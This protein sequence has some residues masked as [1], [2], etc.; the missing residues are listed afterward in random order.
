M[1]HF[2][3]CLK[4]E[5]YDKAITMRSDSRRQP[6]HAARNMHENPD[7]A[8]ELVKKQLDKIL[9]GQQQAEEKYKRLESNYQELKSS[10]SKPKYDLPKNNRDELKLDSTEKEYPS[11]YAEYKNTPAQEANKQF[12]K[13]NLRCF[14]CNRYGHISKECRQSRREKTDRLVTIDSA[15]TR[16]NEGNSSEQNFNANRVGG[17]FDT[18]TED[19]EVYLLARIDGKEHRCLLDSGCELSILPYELVKDYQLMPSY[20]RMRSANDVAIPVLG[21]VEVELE[22]E[23]LTLK[24]RFLVSNNISEIMLGFDFLKQHGIR[25]DFQKRTI[26]LKGHEIALCSSRETSWVRKLVL[27]YDVRIPPR[28]E[29][30]IPGTVLVR[31]ITSSEAWM[32]NTYE[33]KSGVCTSRTLISNENLEPMVRMINVSKEPVNIRSGTTVSELSE[34]EIVDVQSKPTD[35]EYEHLNVMMEKVDPAVPDEIRN[36]LYELLKKYSWNFSKNEY[37]LGCAKG[38]Q[39]HIDTGSAKPFRQTLRR[40]PDQ[41]LPL[42]DEQVELMLQQGIIEPSKGA[43]SSNIVL[44]KKKDGSIRPCIDLRQLNQQVRESGN[45]DIYPLPNMGACLDSMGGSKWF[46]TFDLKAGYHQIEIYPPDAPKTTFLTRKRAW[47]YK[48]VPMGQCNSAQTCQR[49]M[50]SAFQG[51]NFNICLIYM[52]DIFL[53]SNTLEEHL[54][55]LELVLQRLKQV[56]LKLKPSKCYLLQQSVTFLGHRISQEGITTD[57]SRT[58]SIRNW[59]VPSCVKEA[60]AFVSLAAFYK[61]FIASFADIAKPLY[62]LTKKNV[63]FEWNERCQVAFETLKECLVNPPVLAIPRQEGEFILD[64]DCSDVAAAAI[65]HQVIDGEERIISY[66]S[67]MLSKAEQLYCTTKKELLAIVH[68][69]KRFKCY[70]AGP[71]PFLIR[72]DHAALT[73]LRKSV[74]LLGQSARWLQFLEEFN[75]RIAHRAGKASA[76]ADALTRMKCKQCGLDVDP[77]SHMNRVVKDSSNT[78]SKNINQEFFNEQ[79]TPEKIAELTGD[80]EELKVI[81]Y[82]LSTSTVQPERNEIMK[83]DEITKSYWA[84]WPRLKLRNGILYRRWESPDGSSISWQWIPPKSCRQELIKQVHCGMTGGHFAYDKTCLQVQRRAYWFT[85]KTDVKAFCESCVECSTYFRGNPKRQA[86]MQK[87]T[88]GEKFQLVSIDICG[89]FPKSE[90]GNRF[91]MTVVDHFSKMVQAYCMPDHQ[92]STVARELVQGWISQFG[93]MKELLSD[94]GTEFMSSLFQELCRCMDISHLRTTFYRPQCNA[95]CERF[96]R[97]LN[98]ILA[99]IMDDHQKTWDEFVPYALA[100]YRNTVYKST[101]YTPNMIIYGQEVN[102]PVDIVLGDFAPKEDIE[103]VKTNELNST[104]EYVAMLQN[105]LRYSYELVRQNLNKN[106][107]RRKQYYDLK[108]KPRKS[109]ENQFVYYFSPENLSTNAESGHEIIVDPS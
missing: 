10:L 92:A 21:E 40:H 91:I 65:L 101:G 15:T 77:D 62:E 32:T 35:N 23:R 75:Y 78:S 17:M 26:E 53:H 63:R 44:V 55:R 1:K 29:V 45:M 71:R 14:N 80:D 51:L 16:I 82:L 28:S 81:I 56:N 20:R 46:S 13:K 93:A 8:M 69:V 33:I 94:N 105:K 102:N 4:L 6:M 74:N 64:T 57:P 5:A 47:Q 24:V 39:H 89:P 73:F 25:W 95:N 11:V 108:V 50:D 61:R 43:Y 103:D 83:Y 27:Q 72:T 38:V 22:L 41:Y 42:I 67:K 96:H 76:N 3:Y 30:N 109:E 70:L 104:N 87:F 86:P 34:V 107:E 48:R 18:S 98:S 2:R 88:V 106:A 79:W 59:P 49:L 52:D 84:Q 99:K 54:E 31:R 100:A 90:R 12:P 7:P 60:R 19:Q 36:E 37:D 85:W 9:L 97:T 68:F 58:E 66:G